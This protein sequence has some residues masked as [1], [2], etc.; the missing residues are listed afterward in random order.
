MIDQKTAPYAALVLRVSLGVMYLTHSIVLK[1]M[2]F[3]LEGNAQYFE[4]IGLPAVLG[5]ATF[6]AEAI[7]GILLIVGFQTRWVAAALIPILLGAVWVHWPNSW[8][9][10]A[11][12]G[13][14]EYPVFLIAASLVQILLGDGP[15]AVKMPKRLANNPVSC[16][17]AL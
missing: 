9:F 15:H 12:G 1:W 13:G 8:V 10:S 5:Y 17:T 11:E 3:G 7:G 2:T 6:F 4:S 16:F 14:W